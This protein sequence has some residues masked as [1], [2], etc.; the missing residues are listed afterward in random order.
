[1][2]SDMKRY[3]L[4]A[5]LPLVLNNRLSAQDDLLSLVDDGEKEV[6]YTSA[7]FKGTRLINFHTIEGPGKNSLEYRISHHFGDFNSGGY[8]FWGLDGGATIRMGFEYSPDGRFVAGFG[9]SSL[10]KLFDGFLKYKLLRQSNKM[11]VTITVFSG[12]YYTTL[13]DA[14]GST[15][16]A[17][18]S[19]R[20]SYCHQVMIARK[21]NSKFSMQLTPSLVHFNMVDLKSQANDVF[22]VAGLFRYKLTKRQAITFEYGYRLNDRNSGYQ[23]AVGLGY[24]L[25]TGGHVFSMFITNSAGMTEP[26]FFARTTERWQDWGI[27]LGFNISRSF[28]IKSKED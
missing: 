24:E 20:F 1:M 3:L 11:P 18:T 8:N 26:Q 16:Y 21:F 9:R 17:F 28:W 12:L 23:D 19:S 2:T 7:T 27:K 5:F 15:R 25:E 13:K 22:I 4:L 14:Q 10:D 6:I